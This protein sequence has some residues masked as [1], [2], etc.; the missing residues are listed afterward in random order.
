MKRCTVRGGLILTAILAL[1]LALPAAA[2]FNSRLD[3]IIQDEQGKPYPNVTVILKHLE[4]NQNVEV[5]TDKNGRYNAPGL[6]SGLWQITLKDGEKMLFTAQARI[7]T[8][9]D[10]TLSFNLKEIYEK[11]TALREARKKVE[12]ERGKF[13]NMK[14]HFD[15]G[16]AA[17]NQV[18]QIKLVTTRKTADQAAYQ[19]L[20]SE[21]P[22]LAAFCQQTPP[23]QLKDAFTTKLTEIQ[24]SAISDLEQARDGLP[25]NDTNTPTV[26]ANLGNAY[27]EAGRLEDAA[28]TY[29]KAIDSTQ[30][31]Q[32][33]FFVSLGTVQA[34]LGKGAEAMAACE[35]ATALDPAQAGT[36]MRNIVIVMQN[37]GKMKESIEPAK[38]ASQLD[39]TNAEGHFFMARALVAAMEYK[40]TGDKIETVVQPGTAEAFQ[41]Y[42]E[43]AP[44]GRFAK[45]AQESLTMLQ[46]LG[47]G[48]QT[49]VSTRP[50]KKRP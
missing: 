21:I 4:K 6:Q 12:E 46:A 38:K 40:Q 39:P 22:A 49:K 45:D 25:P 19:K 3:G 29:Q 47:V 17:L 31:P 18:R 7:A 20:C 10:Q 2:Q 11:D 9:Q 26:L 36:C 48:I 5:K 32:A 33:A 27:E 34:R 35:K 28:A 1:G 23:E 16:V 37:A 41:K 43:L 14:L 13:E 30:T 15:N 42:L 44:N 24:Q 8:S 50:S